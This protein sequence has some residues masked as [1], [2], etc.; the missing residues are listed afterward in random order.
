MED[1]YRE[2]AKFCET[3]IER[4]YFDCIIEEG[5]DRVRAAEAMGV[6]INAIGKGVHRVRKRARK[7]GYSPECGVDVA[8]PSGYVIKGVSTNY[9]GEGN[10]KQQ[11]VKTQRDRENML[12]KLTDAV[13]AIIEPVRGLARIVTAPTNTSGKFMT[14]YPIAE[15][16]MGMYSCAEETGADYDTKIAETLLL[17]SMEELVDSAPNSDEG[18]IANLAD[19]FH[20]D[21]SNNRTLQSGNILDVDTRWGKVFQVGVRAKRECINLALKKHKHVTV[22]SGIGN[23]DEHSIFALMMMMQAYF[24]N[25]PRVTIKLPFNPFAYHTFGKNLIGLHHGNGVK[26]SNLPLIMASD[27]P[28]AWGDSSYRVFIRGHIHHKEVKEH[29][30]CIVE[31]FRSIAAKDSWHNGAGYRSSRAM[32]AI[33]YDYEGGEHGRHIVYIK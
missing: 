12:E 19:Y 21:N 13:N 29:P 23:H 3:P 20:T 14:L 4:A 9:D 24:E 33:V 7:A 2:L 25:E 18:V 8:V 5:G 10:I 27:M 11:W 17:N 26:A 16:H 22:M 15:P 32:E 6:S 30:G 28:E 31:S 1:N